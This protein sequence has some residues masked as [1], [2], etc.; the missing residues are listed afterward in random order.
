MTVEERE[1]RE[2]DTNSNGI[3]NGLD[4][5][6]TQKLLLD[7]P[8]LAADRRLSQR[9]YDEV[10]AQQAAEDASKR[11]SSLDGKTIALGVTALVSSTVV[12]CSIAILGYLTVTFALSPRRLEYTMPLPLDLVGHD[13]VS[14][15]SLYSLQQY[16]EDG[17]ARDVSL[18]EQ[19]DGMGTQ[20]PLLSPGQGFDVWMR[21][22][23]PPEYETGQDRS[24][25]FGHVTA[26]LSTLAG[27]VTARVSK[28]VALNGRR[29]SVLGLMLW[30]WRFVGVLPRE[31]A[32]TVEL[33]SVVRERKAAPSM[34]LATEIKARAPPGPDILDATIG[35]TLRAGLVQTVLFYV[36]P[37]S[38]L[39]KLLG[40]GSVLA[41]LSGAG[42]VIGCYQAYKNSKMGDTADLLADLGD[43]MSDVDD[44]LL[45]GL[46][47]DDG[48]DDDDMDG[49]TIR[50]P[51]TAPSPIRNDG[52]LTR[53][54]DGPDLDGPDLDGPDL[55]GLRRRRRL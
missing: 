27:K 7:E 44:A 23:V 13:L 36:W 37:Q 47:S 4:A 15:V 1:E 40:V 20:R 29:S 48:D 22:H 8:I 3:S 43:G 55:D 54:L 21:L 14:N 5:D 33:F 52:V 30:P 34:F 10:Q 6:P 25:R 41:A 26:S 19:D 11:P 53:D 28:P 46:S 45:A 9:I 42:V 39:G 49:S 18:L 12:L 17:Q 31:H 32:V 50:V 16:L 24:R 2:D 38:L 51:S 35:V